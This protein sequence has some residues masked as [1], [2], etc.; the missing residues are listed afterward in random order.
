[1]ASIAKKICKNSDIYPTVH[2]NDSLFVNKLPP[3]VKALAFSFLSIDSLL[4]LRLVDKC[5]SE[6]A[7]QEL[8]RFEAPMEL[9]S[10][11]CSRLLTGIWNLTLANRVNPREALRKIT[12]VA[13]ESGVLVLKTPFERR[14]SWRYVEPSSLLALQTELQTK[15]QTYAH[16]INCISRLIKSAVDFPPHIIFSIAP[17]L[18]I[19]H[20]LPVHMCFAGRT[21]IFGRDLFKI[22]SV[23][24][25]K[26]SKEECEFLFQAT[27]ILNP[28]EEDRNSAKTIQQLQ[29]EISASFNTA[30][31]EG[32]KLVL[33]ALSSP[34]QPVGFEAT[35]MFETLA[36]E[37]LV[38]YTFKEIGAPATIR[39]PWSIGGRTIHL[40]PS[41]D[42]QR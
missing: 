31:V 37:A 4:S 15:C 12:Q 11:N 34:S 10:A 26:T 40:N 32:S 8:A 41:P 35:T 36:I 33:Q 39:L 13:I 28:T 29:L 16:R 9:E 21:L 19:Y 20:E 14:A 24:N 18:G 7:R 1:M 27:D 25:F 17:V 6:V 5:T 30:K 22:T 42:Q 2:Q 3:P 38:R 23:I